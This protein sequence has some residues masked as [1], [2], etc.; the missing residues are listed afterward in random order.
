MILS[1]NYATPHSKFPPEMWAEMIP[2]SKRT[3]NAPESF[4]AHFDAQF[5]TAHQQFF[6][7]LEVLVMLQAMAYV[8]MRGTN[9][10]A[11]YKK[12]ER[13]RRV[14]SQAIQKIYIW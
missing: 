4:H 5:Y 3:N 1:E 14:N 12:T 2:S 10:V 8:K 7:F 13:E 9:V 6:V 11:P